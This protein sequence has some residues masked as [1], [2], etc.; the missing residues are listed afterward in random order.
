MPGQHVVTIDKLYFGKDD[1]E[2]DISSGG[3]LEQGFFQTS[4]YQQASS[5]RKSLIIGRKGSGKSAICVVLNRRR[6]D[7]ERHFVLVT[8]DEISSE[9]IRRF[10]LAGVGDAQAKTLLWRYVLGIQTAKFLVTAYKKANKAE[11]LPRPLKEVRQFLV[12]NGE[13]DDLGFLEKVW[14]AIER[15]KGSLSLEA[16]GV[17]AGIELDAPTQGLRVNEQLEVMDRKLTL[18]YSEVDWGSQPSLLLMADKL[19]QVWTNDSNSDAMVVGLLQAAKHL[20][21]ALPFVACAVFLR[22]DIYDFLVFADRDKFRGDEIRIEWTPVDLLKML[23]KRAEA[24]IG[25]Q[26]S[27][28][29]LWNHLFP[30]RIDDEP[31]RDYLVNKSL[32]RPRDVIQL[33]NLCRDTAEKNG[34]NVIHPSDIEEAAQQYS[35]WKLLDLF[36]EYQINFPFLNELFIL[37]QNSS[38]LVSRNSIVERLNTIRDSL[39]RKYPEH[40]TV[41]TV[42]GVV[43]ILF[44]IGF[45]G[46]MRQGRSSFGYEQGVTVQAV[47]EIFVIHPAFREALRSTSSLD[48][49]PLDLN[50]L[51]GRVELGIRQFASELPVFRGSPE[52]QLAYSI[53]GLLSRLQS[54]Y[55][56]SSLPPDVKLEV[57]RNLRDAVDLVGELDAR[58]LED[59]AQEIVAYLDSLRRA[60]GGSGF[61]AGS[62]T[63][64]LI[65]ETEFVAEDIRRLIYQGGPDA[66]GDVRSR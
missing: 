63:L 28:E 48:L 30:S 62:D 3:L 60:L 33:C 17:K 31:I 32:R 34:N 39:Q 56:D 40:G 51:R 14:K 19:E 47:D 4:V 22:Q 65:R 36:G 52:S 66:P 7:G 29:E 42:A 41:F 49:E 5:G 26:L 44:G 35:A 13:V 25:S 45:L 59:L 12:D 61:A 54:L 8:P 50:R 2:T 46:V 1:A 15:L 53:G 18:A 16:F 6:Q 10:Q 23:K 37:F 11:D 24:S 43:E 38:F 21:A 57:R 27:D 64:S 55:G 20:M 9:E 58:S